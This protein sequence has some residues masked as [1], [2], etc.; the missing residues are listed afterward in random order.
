MATPSSSP[1]NLMKSFPAGYQAMLGLEQACRDSALPHPTFELVKLRASMVNG[2]AYCV[3]M[4]WKDARA[5]GE[6]EERLYMLAAW[7][8]ATVYTDAER[9]ALALADAV[10][11]ITG[12][13]VPTDVEAAAREQFGDEQYAALVFSLATINAW[14]R[15]CITGHATPGLYQPKPSTAA[16][17]ASA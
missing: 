5:A 11:H 3:D 14:N 7:H 9:A 16:A 17:S 10:T 1:V 12:A 13:G 4:H 15:I 2:C 6:T 8:E